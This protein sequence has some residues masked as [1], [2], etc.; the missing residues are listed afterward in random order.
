MITKKSKILM[1]ISLF[2]LLFNGCGEE[3]KPQVKKNTIAKLYKTNHELE[4]IENSLND[5]SNN[6][7]GEEPKPQVKKNT[8]VKRYKTNHELE[9]IENSLNDDFNN[10]IESLTS[11]FNYLPNIV[12]DSYTNLTWQDDKRTKE[13]KRD[14][15]GAIKYCKNLD[16]ETYTDWRLPTRSELSSIIN[17]SRNP[18]IKKIFNN[19]ESNYYWSSSSHKEYKSN[20]WNI[21]FSS[22]QIDFYSKNLQYYVRCIREG[23]I[24]FNSLENFNLYKNINLKKRFI[25]KKSYSKQPFKEI[26]GIVQKIVN[27]YTNVERIKKPKLPPMPK[28]IKDE[29]ETKAQ[30]QDRINHIIAKREATIKALQEQYRKDV[31]FRNEKVRYIQKILPQKIQ[32]WKKNA[33]DVVMGGFKLEK[34]SY[35]A[36]T[37]TMYLTMKAKQA[38]YSKKVTINIAPQNAKTFVACLEDVDVTPSFNFEDNQIVLNSIST[39]FQGNSYVA[40]LNAKDFKPEK[41]MVAIKDKKVKFNSAKQM[42]LSL[43]NPNLKDTYQVEAL[44]Y[45]DGKKIRGV[46]YND[47][48]P[49][50]LAKIKP[51]KRDNH[52]W[53]FVIGI[54][55]YTETDN[56]KYSKRSAQ[57]FK[58]VAQKTLGI[59]ERHSYTLIDNRATGTAIKNRLKILLSE[60]KKGDTIYFYYNGHGIPDP[61]KGGEPYMLPSDG[62]PDFIVSEKGFALKN[63]YKE[64]SDSKASKVVAFVD[65]CFS[66]ATDGVS[67]IKGVA[68][69]RLA[70][71][72][73]K[74]NKSKMVVL[75]AGQKKQYSNM[76][77]ER[78]H[79]MFSYFVMKSL[80]EGKKDINM[81]YKEV[82]Y[83]VSEASNELGRLKKQEPTIDGNRK[84]KL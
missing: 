15:L 44:A 30:F 63:I 82:S 66:G 80:L 58:K 41:I 4:K 55:N 37:S 76:Y 64:L 73:V 49:T 65:S 72:K 28:I 24:K 32:K 13:V 77:E 17:K 43:Q 39:N 60:V 20:A 71:K 3:P 19:I 34:R 9:K 57:A 78:G 46:N 8:I 42:R 56:I 25:S 61:L 16:F 35:D 29:Y 62:I 45:K 70:P 12:Y 74:F 5:D 14:W 84:I 50:L 27:L 10:K 21:D 79:R 48:I 2:L 59:S 33:F 54:E 31:E 69:S 67:L 22:G 52:K 7:S 68:G 38:K 36:E 81:L 11:Y 51:T 83:K 26:Q 47:D 40:T 18:S 23:D 6:K 53:L 75:T 1:S